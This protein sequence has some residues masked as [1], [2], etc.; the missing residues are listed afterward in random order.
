MA[1]FV[2]EDYVLEGLILSEVRE[3]VREGK[4]TLYFVRF[5]GSKK[6]GASP[7]MLYF[8][9]L[10]YDTLE[11]LRGHKV[12]VLLQASDRGFNVAEIVKAS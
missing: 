12:N 4:P 9:K 6:Y 5:V 7:Q 10:N 8:G 2:K 1:D 3:F 11:S